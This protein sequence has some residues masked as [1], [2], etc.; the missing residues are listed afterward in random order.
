M[1][2]VMN[3]K[4]DIL[5]G[6]KTVSHCLLSIIF[7]RKIDILVKS[8]WNLLAYFIQT[9]P[10]SG[11]EDDITKYNLHVDIK[12]TTKEKYDTTGYRGKKI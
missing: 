4:E 12:A 3:K 6:E 1:H 5:G 10:C 2:T 7:V 9:S 11:M 8:I